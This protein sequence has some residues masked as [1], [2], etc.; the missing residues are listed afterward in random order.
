M[1]RLITAHLIILPLIRPDN[2]DSAESNSADL[3]FMKIENANISSNNSSSGLVSL[4]QPMTNF[5]A[6]NSIDINSSITED[7]N[8][9]RESAALGLDPI[10][11][12]TS[13][14]KIAEN[15]LPLSMPDQR[16]HF[17]SDIAVNN[18][19]NSSSIEM[20]EILSNNISDESN[21]SIES[22]AN[23]IESDSKIDAASDGSSQIREPKQIQINN[24]TKAIQS[25]L[26][27]PTMP[28]V[29]KADQKSE[30]VQQNA[31][32]HSK[33]ASAGGSSDESKQSRSS[34]GNRFKSL[35]IQTPSWMAKA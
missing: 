30:E 21:R 25:L 20:P 11:N 22:H 26:R 17:I 10:T 24:R 8:D 28:L 29:Q 12:T 1:Q 4:A 34:N 31:E 35:K 14:P 16:D 19:S 27:R 5:I 3:D 9:S 13:N 23:S 15:G 6:S 32:T 18:N 2:N 7:H 33:N